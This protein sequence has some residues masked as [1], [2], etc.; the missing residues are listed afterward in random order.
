MILLFSYSKL[1][2]YSAVIYSL[3]FYLST[4]STIVSGC[5]QTVPDEGETTTLLA[6][7]ASTG[8]TPLTSSM[9]TSTA[10]SSTTTTT[11]SMSTSTAS[12]ST[13][14][15]TGVCNG[16]PPLITMRGTNFDGCDWLERPPTIMQVA[17]F[18]FTDLS[19]A[20]ECI[21]EINCDPTAEFIQINADAEGTCGA[22]GPGGAPATFT[23]RNGIWEDGTVA[24]YGCAVA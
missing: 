23:C 15:T 7:T 22:A 12:S 1:I 8:S 20:T 18:E 4:S 16:C 2:R 3:I 17:P 10:S 11:S 6:S 5:F 13:T 21:M 14:T 9:S 19:T 24:G